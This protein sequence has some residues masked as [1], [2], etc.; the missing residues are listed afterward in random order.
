M[1]A[2]CGPAGDPERVP[3]SLRQELQKLDPVVVMAAIELVAPV[4]SYIGT[5]LGRAA[6]RGRSQQGSS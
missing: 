2:H 5:P 1:R 3:A 6:V 4:T